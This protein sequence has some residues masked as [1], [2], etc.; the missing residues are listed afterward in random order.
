MI[1]ASHHHGAVLAPSQE[2]AM[3][4]AAEQKKAEVVG[5]APIVVDLGKQSRKR[6]KQLRQGTGKLMV[7]LN[8]VLDELRT[9]GKVAPNAQP[10]Y[11]VLKQKPKRRG[12]LPRI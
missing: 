4:V 1:A 7:E 8:E 11:V 9:A 12:F 5:D 10:I 2:V 3:A 6:I